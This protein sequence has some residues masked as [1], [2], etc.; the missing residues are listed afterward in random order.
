MQ[1]HEKPAARVGKAW[2]FATVEVL[3]ACSAAKWQLVCISLC[4]SPATISQYIL[5]VN[6]AT[7]VTWLIRSY[8][9]ACNTPEMSWFNG[10]AD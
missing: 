3:A 5:H 1:T 10:V 2:P 8:T 9:H 7:I 6:V 4:Q